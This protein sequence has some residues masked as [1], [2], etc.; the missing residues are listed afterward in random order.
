MLSV[1]ESDYFGSQPLSE[2]SENL[3]LYLR[4]PL[5]ET[6]ERLVGQDK[7]VHRAGSSDGGS[8]RDIQDQ[9]DLPEAV[10]PPEGWQ[11]APLP[12]YIDGAFD[13]DECLAPTLPFFDKSLTLW[14][15]EFVGHRGDLRQL[16]LRAT[17]EQ[18]HA[19]NQLDFGV[20][21]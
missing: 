10:R 1:E 18:R 14:E 3:K 11:P 2:R 9:C 20:L 12:T 8:P 6:S 17:R 7:S 19:P 13:Q 4:R 15:V 5:E 21:A 16:A